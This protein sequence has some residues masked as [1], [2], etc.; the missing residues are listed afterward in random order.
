MRIVI[1]GRFLSQQTTGVQRMAREFTV[2]LDRLLE[3]GYYPD[4]SV[5]LLVQAGV[6][7]AAL[8]LRVIRVTTIGL[9]KGHVWEQAILPWHRGADWLLNLGN[10]APLISLYRG[11]AVAVVVHD[12]SHRLFPSAYRLAYRLAHRVLGHA[13]MARAK[14]VITVSETERDTITRLY[15]RAKRKI[16]VAQNGGA[17]DDAVTLPVRSSDPAASPYGLYVGS[18]SRR[19]NIDVVLKVAVDLARERNLQFKLVGAFSPIL[20]E[21]TLDVPSDVAGKI[22]FCGQIESKTELA[23]LYRNASFLLFPSLYEASALPP[24]EA[25]TYE[26]PV[27]ASN[28]AALRERCGNAAIYCDP[29][30]VEHIKA[31]A[32]KL[33]DEPTFS[34]EMIARGRDW[35]KRFSWRGQVRDVM[36]E[37]LKRSTAK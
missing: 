35:A 29:H 9:A 10:T 24:I 36:T 37:L 22:E 11:E 16:A 2:A 8:N 4:L 21:T 20:R 14:L 7:L 31:V 13:I 30:D 25:M 5:E 19:K 12:L 28:I 3:D 26:C 17:S 1:N 32:I 27:I 6:C 34:G 33:L 23:S 15:P 18:L